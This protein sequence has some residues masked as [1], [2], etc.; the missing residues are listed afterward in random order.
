NV[1]EL[2]KKSKIMIFDHHLGK[3]I[4]QVFHHN[5]IIKGENPDLYPSASW[6]VNEYLKNKVNL[7]ALLGIVG[8]HE[9]KIKDNFDFSKKINEFCQE[10]NLTFEELH[11]IVYLL[12]S[13]YKIG[14]KKAVEQAPHEL[15]KNKKPQE[16]LD[17]KRW[18]KNLKNL[19]EEISKILNTPNEQINNIIFKKIDTNYNIIST[20]TRK[21]SW[22]TGKDTLV[23]NTGFFKDKDQIYM[24]S[25][26]NAEPIIIKG[27][28]LG[29][30]CGG[31][32]DVLGAVVP[33]EKTNKFIEEIMLFLENKQGD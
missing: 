20:I 23:I 13:N 6:I 3:V 32:K 14:D 17:N 22:D 10:N 29:F 28:E 15:L 7:F 18:N 26:K 11:K 1:L 5:P 19:G 25:K 8:D 9:Q 4:N 24:R 16:I 2:A 12:D 21:I 31:K 33:K 27:K 30:K